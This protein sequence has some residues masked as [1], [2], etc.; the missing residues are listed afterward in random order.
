MKRD[1]FCLSI[2]SL[3][4][5]LDTILTSQHV[6]AEHKQALARDFRA[7]IRRVDESR[8]AVDRLAQAE[9]ADDGNGGNGKGREGGD[10]RNGVH[11]GA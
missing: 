3:V 7:L 6:P 2:I 8:K 5:N 4:L 9:R 11:A 1:E 10:A